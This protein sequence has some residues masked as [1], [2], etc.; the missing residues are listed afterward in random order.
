MMVHRVH[1]FLQS[2]ACRPPFCIWIQRF[3]ILSPLL[4]NSILLLTLSGIRKWF[5]HMRWISLFESSESEVC[6]CGSSSRIICSLNLNLTSSSPVFLDCC[7]DDL[8]F[9]FFFYSSHA[10]EVQPKEDLTVNLSDLASFPTK[11]TAPWFISCQPLQV[12]HLEEICIHHCIFN[13]TK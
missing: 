10:E 12:I 8:L 5:G 3:S 2:C 4:A 6:L 1:V 9:L 7:P 13:H 11:H